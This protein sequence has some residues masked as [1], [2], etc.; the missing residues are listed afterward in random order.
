MTPLGAPLQVG[1]GSAVGGAGIIGII[2]IVGVDD[3]KGKVCK[4]M[5]GCA[6]CSDMVINFVFSLSCVGERLLIVI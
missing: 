4:D 1:T 2:G 6:V 5:A 3:G